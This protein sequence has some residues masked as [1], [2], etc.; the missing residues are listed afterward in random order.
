MIKWIQS[1]RGRG[2]GA[3]RVQYDSL[4]PDDDP[5]RIVSI[6]SNL[7]EFG[8]CGTLGWRTDVT[9]S[10]LIS[11]IMNGHHRSC[12]SRI[13]LMAVEGIS[14]DA[15]I[16]TNQF[17]ERGIIMFWSLLFQ[18]L[19]DWGLTH[20]ILALTIFSTGDMSKHLDNEDDDF[21]TENW[22]YDNILNYE[23]SIHSQESE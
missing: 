22:Y 11:S 8:I 20:G 14:D 15:R 3:C 6:V 18:I 9:C 4:T 10:I 12:P 16:L 5:I 2:D 17:S 1:S 19:C 23:F 7:K 13:D 21:K